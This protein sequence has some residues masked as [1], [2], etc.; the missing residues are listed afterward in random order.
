MKKD[1]FIHFLKGF[2]I[3]AANVIPGVSGGTIALLTGIFERL[4]DSLKSFTISNL[5]LLL[6]FKIKA[7]A[8]HT[9]LRFLL[10]VFSGV[11]VSIFT[12]ARLLEYLFAHYAIFV[13]AFFF[14]LILA[15]VYYVGKTI[16]K[17]TLPVILCFIIG[18]TLAALISFQNPA[19]ENQSFYYLVLCGVVA[20]VSMI[21]PGLSGSFILILMGNYNLIMI[22]SVNQLNFSV[23][24]PVALGVLIGL[25]SFAHLLSWVYKKYKNQ[26]IASL[27]GFI[28]GSLITLWPW[29][30]PIYLMENGVPVLKKN[31]QPVI[32]NYERYIPESLNS[33]VWLV[34]ALVL[35]GIL[36]IYLVE[37]LAAKPQK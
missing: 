16:T 4:I 2:G 14:G 7:F 30:N 10:A 27:T 24:L 37:H 17:L 3:G 19:T 33:E 21:L 5:K 13:W 20:I 15:S 18:T 1:W 12:F 28:L 23:L 32:S 26:T 8:E 29:K 36:S 34:C 9:D 35:T 6:H 22:E 25:P 31:A 11:V